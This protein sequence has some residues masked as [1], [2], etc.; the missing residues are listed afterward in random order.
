MMLCRACKSLDGSTPD[1]YHK[2]HSVREQLERLG[3]GRDEPLSDQQILDL[4]ETEGNPNNGGGYFEVRYD[5]EGRPSIHYDSDL[6]SPPANHRPV[7]VPG[8]IGS[9]VVGGSGISRFSGPPG[10]PA[11]GG[12]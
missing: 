10:I 4:C 11:P 12:F 1:N 8:E 5:N 7:G 6:P 3:A 2:I 9:P